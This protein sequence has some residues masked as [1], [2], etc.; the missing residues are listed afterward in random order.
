MSCGKTQPFGIK[1]HRSACSACP[2]SRWQSFRL[3]RPMFASFARCKRK[4]LPAGGRK[5]PARPREQPKSPSLLRGQPPPHPLAP[6]AFAFAWRRSGLRGQT[7][8]AQKPRRCF[9]AGIR[10]CWRFL[11][12][13]SVAW[14]GFSPVFGCFVSRIDVCTILPELFCFFKR[15]SAKTR[16]CDGNAQNVRNSNGILYRRKRLGSCEIMQ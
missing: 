16:R 3:R 11:S 5:C 10:F 1:K 15:K 8:R 7:R 9:C 14:C 4:S 6:R 12:R 13:L 2:Q